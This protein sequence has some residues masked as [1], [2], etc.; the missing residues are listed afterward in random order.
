MDTYDSLITAT[1]R[2]E[3]TGRNIAFDQVISGIVDLIVQSNMQPGD[4]LPSERELADIFHVGRPTVREAVSALNMLNIVDIRQFDGLYVASLEPRNLVIPFKMYARIGK[5]D[6]QQLFEVRLIIETAAIGMAAFKLSDEKVEEIAALVENEDPDNEFAFA[7]ADEKLHKT[8][9]EGAGNFLLKI[10]MVIL[11][12]LSSNSRMVTGQFR[13][14]RNMVHDDHLRIVEALKSR[15]EAACKDAMG[16][17][18]INLEKIIGI[19]STI[20]NEQFINRLKSEIGQ[21]LD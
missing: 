17:H 13:E 16:Q 12:N 3:L 19:Y 14:V 1:T 21:Q 8:I 5:I 4:K 7:A 2:S 20:Y 10:I 18:I 9:Y 11:S 6:L 15:N